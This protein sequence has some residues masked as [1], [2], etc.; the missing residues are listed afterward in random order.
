MHYIIKLSSNFCLAS[1]DCLYSLKFNLDFRKNY[2]LIPTSHVILCNQLIL[3]ACSCD[4]SN[5]I[6]DLWSIIVYVSVIKK[7]GNAPRIKY[8]FGW[9]RR[10]LPSVYVIII[11]CF[12]VLPLPPPHSNHKTRL[13]MCLILSIMTK[14]ISPLFKTETGIQ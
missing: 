9:M 6:F 11:R 14:V 12:N 1:Y 8:I 7:K 4:Y 13:Q 5:W 2:I 3:I 10:H